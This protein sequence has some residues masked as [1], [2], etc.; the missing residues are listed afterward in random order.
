MSQLEELLAENERLKQHVADLQ[1]GMFINCV[2]CGHRYGP[3]KDTPATVIEA[4]PEGVK[5]V[6]AKLS[7]IPKTIELK[8]YR[9][10]FAEVYL[11]RP[12][13]DAEVTCS[14]DA[15]TDTWN[16]TDASLRDLKV[17]VPLYCKEL[18]KRLSSVGSGTTMAE[19]LKNHIKQCPKHPL[20][21][22]ISTL[23]AL[24]NWTP[25]MWTWKDAQVRATAMIDGTLNNL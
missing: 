20:S 13:S 2:Y 17:W 16:E 9:R 8:H 7:H 10:V 22:T 4:D 23:T 3:Q 24:K 11:D 21:K 12:A 25:E 6:I 18:A 19:A 14:G 1:S 15:M 5:R